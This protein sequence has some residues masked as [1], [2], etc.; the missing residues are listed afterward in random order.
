VN[1]DSINPDPDPGF[2]DKKLQKNTAEILKT[3]FDK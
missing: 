2:D 1:T 3:F